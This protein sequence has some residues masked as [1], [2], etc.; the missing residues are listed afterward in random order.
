MKIHVP[1]SSWLGNIEGLLRNIDFTDSSKL[2]I[3]FDIKWISIHPIV[4][5]IIGAMGLNV[6]HDN[7][8]VLGNIH[9]TADIKMKNQLIKTNLLKLLNMDATD[10]NSELSGRF[11]PVTQI[12]N[13]AR[14]TDIIR[15]LVPLLH[16]TP[17]Q[18]DAIK[19]VMSEMIRNVLEHSKSPNGA[20][21]CAQYIKSSN[22]VSVGIVDTG[23]GLKTALTQ[24]HSPQNDMEAIKLGLT[25]GITGTTSRIG[26]T[27]F[28]AGAGLFFTK[29]I[30]KVS[31]NFF[32][33][34]T[35]N[36]LYRLNKDKKGKNDTA[37]N[38]DPLKD[39]CSIKDNLNFWKGTVVGFDISLDSES[40]FQELLKQIR[41]V[42]F[43]DLKLKKKA[44]YKKPK[45]T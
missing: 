20:V 2:D 44:K 15:D 36:S 39:N 38:S 28:N 29:S 18:A 26:G 32:I 21:M 10:F 35:G 14:L 9:L 8:G 1:Y 31:N 24:F 23:I 41:D 16:T 19:Y 7:P 43:L 27:E 25:P 12:R 17:K 34:Y 11:I 6:L 4:I 40:E 13:S 37:L 45:F 42:Y 33:L 22:K 3:S 30:A 5:S